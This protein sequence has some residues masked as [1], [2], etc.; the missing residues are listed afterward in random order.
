MPGPASDS[1]L[2]PDALSL[3]QCAAPRGSRPTLKPPPQAQVYTALEWNPDLTYL[4]KS[5]PTSSPRPPAFN[6]TIHISVSGLNSPLRQ[7]GCPTL[8]ACMQPP[9]QAH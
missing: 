4:N 3:D 1:L 5:Q 6:G 2:E 7:V 9:C 8:H